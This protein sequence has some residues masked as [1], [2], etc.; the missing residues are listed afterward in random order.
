MITWKFGDA[1]LCSCPGTKPLFRPLYAVYVQRTSFHIKVKRGVRRDI[2]EQQCPV[3]RSPGFT[4][5]KLEGPK[6]SDPA[7]NQRYGLGNL[8]LKL[9]S[10]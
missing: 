9:F 6:F 7:F 2:L 3:G 10:P 8:D 1:G 5:G 4:K